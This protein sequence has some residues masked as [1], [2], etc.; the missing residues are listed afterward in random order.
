[1]PFTESI[2]SLTG[3]LDTIDESSYKSPDESSE[4]VENENKEIERKPLT[5]LLSDIDLEAIEKTMKTEFG[6]FKEAYPWGGGYDEKELP[7]RKDTNE[8]EYLLRGTLK[9]I[10][11]IIDAVE[12][13]DPYSTI[14]FL[15]KSARPGS[16]L[17]R[18]MVGMLQD[19][20]YIP[21]DIELPD[22]KFMDVGKYGEEKKI[23]SEVTAEYVRE[24]L[25]PDLIGPRV[26]IVDEF[27]DKGITLTN[28][29][30]EFREIYEKY[31]P[32]LK[33]DTAYHFNENKLSTFWYHDSRYISGVRDAEIGGNLKG[34]DDAISNNDNNLLHNF[35]RTS[36][37]VEPGGYT[38]KIEEQVDLNTS[39]EEL[40]MLKKLAI[41]IPSREIY[42]RLFNFHN[43]EEIT[44]DEAKKL[45]EHNFPTVDLDEI[46]KSIAYAM[47]TK[48]KV[49]PKNLYDYFRYAGGRFAAPYLGSKENINRFRHMLDRL[50]ELAGERI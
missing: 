21:K 12:K 33:V 50:V 29:F 39:L 32:N 4:S 40:D 13:G 14:I 2:T 15:D 30:K 16:Y 28:A 36:E 47:G 23:K 8:S 6:E 46:S 11:K 5:T 45:I 18:V 20:E 38:S 43:D 34:I 24:T 9:L 3:T 31:V 7:R 35:I 26:L 22:I 41:S 17:Y 37:K 10:D 48:I 49:D 42:A 44:I 1:M 25:P 27:R 19:K